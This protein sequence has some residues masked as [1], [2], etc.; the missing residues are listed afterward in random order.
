MSGCFDNNGIDA[1]L[2]KKADRQIEPECVGAF[3]KAIV[4]E[5]TRATVKL[6]SDRKWR[7]YVAG[8]AGEDILP[9]FVEMRSDGKLYNVKPKKERD[10]K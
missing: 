10:A 8:I 3:D 9:G 1:E 4:E 7:S 2:E 5:H 6:K